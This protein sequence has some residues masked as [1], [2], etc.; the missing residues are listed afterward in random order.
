MNYHNFKEGKIMIKKFCVISGILIFVEGL[1]LSSGLS[2]ELPALKTIAMGTE[3]GYSSENGVY[4]YSYT[5]SNPPTN[6]GAL[7]TIDIDIS[8]PADGIE[9]SDEELING[10]GYLEN[11]SNAILEKSVPGIATIPMVPI[12]IDSPPNWLGGLSVFGTAGWGCGELA[13]MDP[14]QSMKGYRITSH[15]LPGIRAY[16]AQPYLDVDV[17]ASSGVLTA[18]TGPEDLDK[19]KEDL[20][21][22]KNSV[23]AN[24][25]TIGPTA[26]PAQF[27]AL[28][29][30]AY[31]EDL[32][33]QAFEQGW[34]TNEG[35][36]KS[37]DVKLDQA[38][39]HLQSGNQK[40]ASNVLKAF[41]NEVSAQGCESFADCPEG[42][43]L[44]PEA[45]AL[46]YFN[47]QYL[48]ERL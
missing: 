16:K 8:M 18:P 48:L 17:L 26:P 40:A 43:H 44:S 5:L 9:L 42:K 11:S 3:V 33:H 47:G 22:I 19:Y 23:S 25:K 28:G 41:L 27:V 10:P 32:K 38:R 34:I 13:L 24:G 39:K 36:V 20:A 29:F 45:W 14:G 21:N 37:L 35:V 6:T 1:T 15:G 31:L 2:E 30:L 7:W 12:G 4:T 46:L